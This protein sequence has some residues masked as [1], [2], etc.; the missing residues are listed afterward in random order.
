MIRFCRVITLA[1]VAL[2]LCLGT[3]L[4]AAPTPFNIYEGSNLRQIVQRGSLVVGMEL[5]FWPFE[6]VDDQG[7]PVGFD[8][9]IAKTI[10]ERLGVKLE[11]K[12]MEWTG[13]IPALAAGKIDL[14][15]SGITGTLERAKAITFTSPY[16]TTGLCA[17]LSTKKASDVLAVDALNAPG[18][19]IAVKTGTTAD[20][21][22]SKR[23]PKATINRYPD[24]TA[25]AKDVVAGRADAFFYDQISIAKHHKQNP[26]TT[27]ALL[28]PFTYE[29]FC[30]ALQKGDFDWWQW[31]E[32]F[33]T[34]IK[35]DG[36]LE[37]LRA[38]HFG[39]LLP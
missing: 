4:A 12:D 19:V 20:I 34:T 18:R 15:I 7:R 3:A 9:D 10:A 13:L 37:A 30:I 16:F 39:N 31:L 17:L 27:K 23:F 8:V 5:K 29:P 32:M 22:A 33:L 2:T 1:F 14:I 25:C 11:I 38:K 36:T 21:V 26:D 6:Y 28:T 24:E 35:A